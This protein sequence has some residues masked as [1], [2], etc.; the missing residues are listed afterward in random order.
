VAFGC[1]SQTSVPVVTTPPGTAASGFATLDGNRIRYESFGTGRPTVV[2]IHGWTGDA[3]AWRLVTP[4]LAKRV[5]V[6]ALDLPGHGQSDKPQTAYSMEFYA[7]AVEAVMRAAGADRAVLVGHSMG[8]PIIR[9][10]YRLYPEKTLAL[11]S[12]DGALQNLYSGMLDPVIEQLRTPAYK[13]IASKFIAS[14]FANPG[15][16]ELRDATVATTVATPQYVMV[17]SFEGMRDPII[18][19]DDPIRVPLLVV[20]ANS[21]YWTPQYVEYVRKLAPEVD[22]RVIEGTGHFVQLEKPQELTAAILAF[23]EKNRLLGQ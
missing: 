4:E 5:R 11:V 1:A 7:R 20:N 3:N 2:L 8:G 14:M 9:Q 22:Y 16:D 12:V 10:F 13:D 17:S 18:W 6:V 23:L 19:N 21:P 15:T